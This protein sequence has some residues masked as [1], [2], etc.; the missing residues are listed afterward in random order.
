MSNYRRNRV[1]GGTYF[2]TVNL[3]ERRKQILVDHIDALRTA[4]RKTRRK[5]PFHIDAWVILPD[6]M[7]CI[8]TLP[9]GDAKYSDRWRAIKKYFT[10]SIP[11]S[12]YR[13]EVRI[14]R[15][16]RGIWQRRFWEHTIRDDLDY[17]RHMDYI[18]FNPVKHGLVKSVKDWPHSTF[19]RLV[20]RGIYLPEW[21]EDVSLNVGERA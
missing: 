11:D 21:G 4:I 9:E 13:S 19:H 7:H 10:K 17:K 3:L 6:H 1:P 20:E 18:H 15:N 16:E 12:E 2:F 8:W 14:K 5:A